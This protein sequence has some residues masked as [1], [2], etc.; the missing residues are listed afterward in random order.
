[1]QECPSCHRCFDDRYPACP[2]DGAPLESVYAGSCTLDGKYRLLSRLG[3]GGM[4]RVYRARH[5]GLQ[6]LM[7]VKLL[8]PGR[9]VL[10]VF[11][12]RFEREAE[13]LGRLEHPNVVAVTDFGSERDGEVPYLVMELLE[14]A[15]LAQR[16][17][18]DGPLSLTAALP[19]FDAIADALDSAHEAGILHRDL[20]PSNVVLSTTDGTE[21]RVKVLDFGLSR[22]FSDPEETPDL[23]VPQRLPAGRKTAQGDDLTATDAVLGTPGYVAPEVLEH[24]P[25]SPATDLYSFGALVHA[26]LIG[27]PP[28]HDAAAPAAATTAAA[29]PASAPTLQPLGGE[30]DAVLAAAL[31]RDPAARPLSARRFVAA[32]RRAARRLLRRRW[33]RREA[34]RRL[35]LATL[36]GLAGALLCDAFSAPLAGLEKRL[37][38]ARLGLVS[39]H[40]PTQPLMLVLIDDATLAADPTPLPERGDEVGT[41]LA[42]ALEAGAAGVGIDLLL[43]TAWGRSPAFSEL[44]LRHP[45]KIVLAAFSPPEGPVIGPEVLDG[46]TAAALGP[47]QA[48]ELFGFVNLDQDADGIVRTA[49]AAFRDAAGEPRASF[50]AKVARILL[51]QHAATRGPEMPREPFRID[52]SLDW[53]RFERLSW[54]DLAA[55]LAKS[56]DRFRGRFLLLGAVYTGVGDGPYRVPQARDLPGEIPGPMLQA[57]TAHTLLDGATLREAPAGP[58]WAAAALLAALTAA[59]VLLAGRVTAVVSAP[60]AITAWLGATLILFIS[61]RLL[62]PAAPLSAAVLTI[63]AGAALLRR[64]LPSSPEV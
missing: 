37:V 51:V 60:M 44:L 4:G 17:R 47:H 30:L 20:K 24:R 49:R 9:A 6:R 8:H 31:A 7:A 39:S 22:F 53:T 23:D 52:F 54:R 58:V 16:L 2:E 21:Q 62:L 63:A 36:L 1:M 45:E 11:V 61:D 41:T 64:W 27:R 26:T 43:P 57:L 46:L 34:P 33:L 25:L 35:A 32:L 10:P 50:A 38:D 15:T 13:I 5:L 42:R 29:V 12:A 55:S 56:P 14:G 19:I 18:A 28:S 3:G 48:R 40:A 59:V